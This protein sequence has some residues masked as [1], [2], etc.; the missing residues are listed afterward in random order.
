MVVARVTAITWEMWAS[1]TK[2]GDTKTFNLICRQLLEES[3]F[4]C[5][6]E[7]CVSCKRV[8]SKYPVGEVNGWVK[9]YEA[10]GCRSTLRA[11]PPAKC[12]TDLVRCE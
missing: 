10:D 2:L 3:L 9:K 4:H 5:G 8:S 11:F 6:D 7:L 1:L 12:L